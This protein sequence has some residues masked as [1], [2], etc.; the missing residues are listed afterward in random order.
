MIRRLGIGCVLVA[1][2][3]LPAGAA[4]KTS[5]GEVTNAA[6]QCKSLRSEM[7]RDAFREEFGTNENGRNAFGKCV[8]K[9]SRVEHRAAAKALRECKAEYLEDADAFLEKYGTNDA[10]ASFERPPGAEGDGPPKPPGDARPQAALRRAMHK[11]VAL[12]LR[13]KRAERREALEN[14]VDECKAE[15]VADPAAFMEKY[16]PDDVTETGKFV[17]FGRCVLSKIKVPQ[18]S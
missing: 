5:P 17:A 13:A 1:A 9:H 16:G 15:L 4:A 6:K 7:G 2:L 3:A 18:A 11:C 10:D 12:K 8:A 14:A